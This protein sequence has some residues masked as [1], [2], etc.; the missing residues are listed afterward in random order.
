MEE[1]KIMVRKP[2]LLSGQPE[3]SDKKMQRGKLRPQRCEDNRK[4]K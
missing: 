3:D 1:I 4:E 2:C